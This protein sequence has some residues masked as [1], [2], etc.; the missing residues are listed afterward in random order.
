M[1]YVD[2]LVAGLT[3]AQAVTERL[4]NEI[5]QG[6]LEPGERLRQQNVAARF[7]VSTT[8]VREAFIALQRE[9]LVTGD[10]YKGV[11]VFRP[12]VTDLRE[13]YEL[14]IAL[15]PLAAELAAEQLDERDLRDLRSCLD[16]MRDTTDSLQYLPLN[17]R[18]HLRIYRAAHRAKLLA[19]IEDLRA[20]ARAYATLF[21]MEVP[22]SS[23]TQAEHEAIFAAL[24]AHDGPRAREA[25]ASHLQHTLD[26]VSERLAAALSEDA[27][28]PSA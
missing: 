19:M 28:S 18:F 26:V 14:R 22:D 5:L 20:A 25:M 17:H 16:E 27:A 24:A 2:E 6:V 12:T 13:N 8:P 7:G 3:R 4:R 21:A 1:H 23:E 10:Q 11:V 15:E 9:G